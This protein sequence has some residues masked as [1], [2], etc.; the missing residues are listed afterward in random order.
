MADYYQIITGTIA[1]L[2]VTNADVRLFKANKFGALP[3]L[4]LLALGDSV[5]A[6]SQLGGVDSNQDGVDYLNSGQYFSCKLGELTIVGLFCRAFFN[7][8]DK[9][10]VVVEP[11]DDGSYF[12]YA[13]R[14]PI[15]HR[16]WL[17]PNSMQGTDVSKKEAFRDTLILFLFCLVVFSC[18]ELYFIT[19]ENGLFFYLVISLVFVL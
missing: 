14:R 2:E 6:A 16:L 13:L 3:A 15:D 8:G 9:V 4:G 17:H 11:L 10:E 18:F 1:E 12:A 5:A 19:L 7:N